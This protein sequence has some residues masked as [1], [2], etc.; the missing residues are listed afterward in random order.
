MGKLGGRELNYASDIDV[1]FVGDGDGHARAV[2]DVARPSLAGR[3]RPAPRR[4]RRAADPVPRLLPGLL[5]PV[6]RDVGVPGPAQGP[7]GGAATPSARR[8]P[9]MAAAGE[10]VWGRPFGAD[11]L[12]AVRAMKARAEGD[13]ARRGLSR[14]GA[15]AGAGRHPRHRV[16]RPAAPAGPR[17]GRPRP[18]V[19]EHVDGARRAG[20]RP[21]TSRAE[22]ADRARGGLPVPA[23]H[24]APP[25]AGRG[26]AGPRPSDVAGCAGAAWPG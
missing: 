21:A 10:R 15:E 11:E 6:G 2:L 26:P 7:T 20:L 3:R 8:A 4:P 9:F 14:A 22:D 5:G 23:G 18:A 17:P 24:R 19:A 13:V 1:M 25:A 16:R 12:R